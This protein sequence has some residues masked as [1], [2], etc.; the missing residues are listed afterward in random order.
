VASAPSPQSLEEI[1]PALV[2]RIAWS[3][4]GRRG[5]VRIELGSGELDGAMLLVATEGGRVRVA[6]SGGAGVELESWRERI[7]KRLEDKGLDV[8][9]T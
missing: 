8:E 5:V 4:D 3:G 9:V 7:A 1:L 6:L 2:R